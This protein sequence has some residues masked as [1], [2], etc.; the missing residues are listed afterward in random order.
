MLNTEF[1]GMNEILVDL[2]A[3][4]GE[5]RWLDL[6]Y[7]FEHRAFVDPL[8]RHRDVLAGK[9]GN[10]QIPKMI[11]SVARST[12]STAFPIQLIGII[13]HP[14]NGRDDYQ[15]IDRTRR[16]SSAFLPLVSLTKSIKFRISSFRQRAKCQCASRRPGK[17]R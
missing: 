16:A 4:T 1:G 6:S 3:D 10:T 13:L 5:Q 9:H 11:G 12:A 7:K 14:Q 2:Y 8:K 17:V 15:N